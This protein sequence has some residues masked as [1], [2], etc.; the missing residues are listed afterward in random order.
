MRRKQC[1]I[2]RKPMTPDRRG[3][4]CESCKVDMALLAAVHRDPPYD[5]HREAAERED[6]LR[7]R[8]RL[9]PREAQR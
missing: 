4:Y 1:T 7:R 3:S 5:E 2:C 6:R 8:S 9:V